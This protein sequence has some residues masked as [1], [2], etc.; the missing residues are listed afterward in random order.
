MFFGKFHPHLPYS[1]QPVKAFY[2]FYQICSALFLVPIWLLFYIKV[3]NRPR[4]SWSISQ[5]ITVKFLRKMHKMSEVSNVSF[6]IR[7]PHVEGKSG[8]YTDFKFI[9]T[10]ER[11]KMKGVLD[12]DNLDCHPLIGTYVWPKHRANLKYNEGR[13]VESDN[14]RKLVGIYVHG[15]AYAHMSAHEDCQTS[16]IPKRLMKNGSFLEVH[17]VE[18]RLVHYATFPGALLDVASVSYH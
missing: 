7:D 18:Y 12:I 6:H 3:S 16:I 1:K 11:K 8:K 2:I 4:K 9:P 13:D 5:S 14:K 10:L 15:G 17:S